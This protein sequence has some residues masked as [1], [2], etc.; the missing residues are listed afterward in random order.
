M[1]FTSQTYLAVLLLA[2]LAELAYGQTVTG[3]ILG[4]VSDSGGGAVSQSR[5]VIIEENTGLKR[6]LATD[7]QGGYLATFLPVGTYTVTIEKSGF[8]KAILTGTVLQVDQQIRLDI[9][10]EVGATNQE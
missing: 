10:L 7:N 4:S 5:V 9:S 2:I 3:T 6:E 1:R 8:R